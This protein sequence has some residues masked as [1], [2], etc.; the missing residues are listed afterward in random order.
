MTPNEQEPKSDEIITLKK[1]EETKREV[2]SLQQFQNATYSQLFH[3]N[4]SL[5][6]IEVE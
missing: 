3:P 6:K 1:D 4:S 2:G 5:E